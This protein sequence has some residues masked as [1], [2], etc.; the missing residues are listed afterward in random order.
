VRD[1]RN[2]PSVRT[3]SPRRLPRQGA[4]FGVI[5]FCWLLLAWIP[6]GEILTPSCGAA[7]S[8]NERGVRSTFRLQQSLVLFVSFCS[9]MRFSAMVRLIYVPFGSDV[10]SRALAEP[11]SLSQPKDYATIGF[12]PVRPP[13]RPVCCLHALTVFA[14]SNAI[15]IG[16]TPPGT[17]VI[18]RHFGATFSKS[19]S[20]TNR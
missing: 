17:G 7:I 16:P 20:P 10:S 18:A 9:A 3:L 19:T 15:V 2:V 5:V 8:Q 1:R 6:G 12:K 14:I 11:P 13:H 4:P